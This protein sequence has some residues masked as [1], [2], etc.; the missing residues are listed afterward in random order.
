MA[1]KKTDYIRRL[2]NE[3]KAFQ[4]R[5]KYSTNVTFSLESRRIEDEEQTI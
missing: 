5:R 4:K 2:K 1:Y 3:K